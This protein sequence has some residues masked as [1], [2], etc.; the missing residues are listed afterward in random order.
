MAAAALCALEYTMPLLP[1]VHAL[2]KH[3]ADALLEAG[4]KISLPVQ[5]NMINLDL[6]AAGIPPAAFVEYGK[7][8]GVTVFPTGR[9][10]FH[11]QNSPA[12]ASRLV[13]ALTLLIE[14]RR[15][16]KQLENHKVTGGYM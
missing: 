16:G 9:L 15:A 1:R 13:E 12:A 5:T 10:A 6:E 14:D 8:A 7:R 3:T 2:T 4:Y 11:H